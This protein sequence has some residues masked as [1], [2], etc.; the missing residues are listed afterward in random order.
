M[1]ASQAERYSRLKNDRDLNVS[2]LRDTAAV[3][4]PDLIVWYEKPFRKRL[5]KA[6]AGQY[7]DVLRVTESATLQNS[8][9]RRQ[10]GFFNIMSR[11]MRQAAS[12]LV[13]FD[14]AAILTGRCNRLMGNDLNLE[15]KG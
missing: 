1:F 6:L 7:R 8:V 14:E 10:F 3:G 5:R 13:P 2:L 11:A 12:I 4:S 9:W 15:W